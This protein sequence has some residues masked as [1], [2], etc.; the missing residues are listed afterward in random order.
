[1][2]G[3]DQHSWGVVPNRVVLAARTKLTW[4]V[5]RDAISAA[6]PGQFRRIE[7]QRD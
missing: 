1:M 5:Y 4:L 6:A 2:R 3:E 7:A